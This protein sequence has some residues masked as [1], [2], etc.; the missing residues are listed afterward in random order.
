MEQGADGIFVLDENYGFHVA[1]PEFCKMVGYSSGELLRLTIL[2]TYP[3]DLRD[4]AK[5]RNDRIKSGEKLYFERVFKR[6]DGSVFPAE[7]SARRLADGVGFG[8][9]ASAVFV[10]H[11][12]Y[13]RSCMGKDCASR[14]CGRTKANYRRHVDVVQQRVAA[15]VGFSRR[16]QNPPTS[17][18]GGSEPR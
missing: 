17:V 1:N 11:A 3:E 16:A 14:G 2:D 9:A 6:K 13:Q 8:Y 7:M 15:P 10:A 12:K 4:M 5:A 18:G